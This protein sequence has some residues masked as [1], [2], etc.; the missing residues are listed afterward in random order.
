MNTYR[1]DWIPHAR[2]LLAA[3]WLIASNRNAVTRA[4]DAVDK[5]LASDP[6][7][8]GK[9]LSEGLWRIARY[10]LVAYYEIDDTTNTATVTDLAFIP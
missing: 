9:E 10:P 8:L 7:G 5:A 1:V 6:R 2:T 4:Q 3:A